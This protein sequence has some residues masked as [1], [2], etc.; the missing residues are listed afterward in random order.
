MNSIL[1]TLNF[2]SPTE[3]S[4]VGTKGKNLCELQ[5]RGGAKAHGLSAPLIAL[6]IC[7]LLQSAV[8]DLKLLGACVWRRISTARSGLIIFGML[9]AD[10]QPLETANSSL[11]VPRFCGS[12]G[13]YHLNNGSRW[14]SCSTVF[15]L[16]LK[17]CPRYSAV[18]A[19]S[20]QMLCLQ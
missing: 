8:S 14:S 5:C 18:P 1:I 4:G 12:A 19:R 17:F 3:Y 20:A 6:R 9:H 13:L 10:W 16:D 11:C 2:C 15:A 7:D